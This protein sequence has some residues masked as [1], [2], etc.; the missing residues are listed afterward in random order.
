MQLAFKIG[1]KIT[2]K[3]YNTFLHHY[4]SSGY[5]FRFS[6]NET[7]EVYIIDMATPVHEFIVSRLQDFFKVPNNGDVDDSL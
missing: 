4:G 1:S 3:N 6:L 2:I 7:G 5:K